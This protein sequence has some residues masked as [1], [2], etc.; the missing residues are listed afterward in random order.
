MARPFVTCWLVRQRGSRTFVRSREFTQLPAPPTIRSMQRI[1]ECVP[2]ISNGREPEIYNAVA[3]AVTELERHGRPL[4]LLDVDPGF[5]T[6]RTVITFAGE[7]EAVLEAALALARRAYELIDMTQQHGAHPRHGA[8]DVLPFVPVRGVSMDDCVALAKRAGEALGAL[9]VPVWLYEFAASSEARRNLSDLRAGEYEAL[10]HKLGAPEWQPDY[11]PGA[12]SEAVARTG[13]CTVGARKFLVAYNINF[14][15]RSVKAVADIA[16]TIR[17]KGRIARTPAGKFLRDADGSPVHQPGAFQH[18]KAMG[19]YIPQ[20]ACAQLTMNLTDFEAT[21]V[22]EVFDLVCELGREKGLRVTGS[23]LVGLIPLRALTDAGRWFLEK[24]GDVCTGVSEQEL[25][26]IAV[27][28]LGL[29][30]LGP[31]DARSRVLEYALEGSAAELAQRRPLAHMR[32]SEFVELLA[33]DAPAPGGG[34]VSALA[35]AL[36]AGLAA[37]VPALTVGKKGY[38]KVRAVMN[39]TAAEAQALKDLYLR[40]VDDDTA[41]FNALLDAFKLPKGSPEDSA[42][43]EAAIAAA[44]REAVEVPLTVLRHAPRVMELCAI[45]AGQGNQNALSDA[46]TGAALAYACA[47]GAHANVLINLKGL[48]ASADAPQ[49]YVE[50]S[51]AFASTSL[52]QAEAAWRGIS[53]EVA[54]T[55]GRS[56]E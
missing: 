53:A 56:R 39:E 35:G 34:S 30:E 44:T 29:D 28:S 23:E 12:F 10:P 7:P 50:E 21:P 1:V 22:H 3:A 4:R 40:L 14:N 16:L 43:R 6:N 2:N 26:R 55:F 19:W 18:L 51:T 25:L 36:A 49:A 11:G 38:K 45:C 46:L 20:Y 13:V 48:Q 33:S 54:A 31:F 47:Q 15:T 5:D 9:G 27:K 8:V 17:E 37:M 41:A 32:I 52:R 42:A 24:Q